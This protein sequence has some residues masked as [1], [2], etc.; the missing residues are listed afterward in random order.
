MCRR[1]WKFTRSDWFRIIPLLT[2]SIAFKWVDHICIQLLAK[3]KNKT[4]L[5]AAPF[6][7]CMFVCLLIPT[8][9]WWI[10]CR[11][12]FY[13]GI[14]VCF[15]GKFVLGHGLI[16]YRNVIIR[17]I[18]V[19]SPCTRYD[20]DLFSPHITTYLTNDELN[21]N[22]YDF[23]TKKTWYLRNHKFIPWKRLKK[24]K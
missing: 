10:L 19:I 9:P 7:I 23:H 17:I 2:F 13:L 20:D 4:V 11:S 14:Y 3:I 1:F 5:L 8:W 12:V 21:L 15:F 24:I 6:A 16:L 22:Y 18:I